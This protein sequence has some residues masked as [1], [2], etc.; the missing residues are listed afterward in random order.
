MR[1]IRYL[2][3]AENALLLVVFVT[4]ITNVSS[5]SESVTTC[6]NNKFKTKF[7]QKFPRIFAKVS[8]HCTQPSLAVKIWHALFI[9]KNY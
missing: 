3:I 7:F 1:H 6:N 8:K 9:S 2:F 4:D 5:E